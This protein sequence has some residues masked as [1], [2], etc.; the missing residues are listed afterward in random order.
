MKPLHNGG[1]GARCGQAQVWDARCQRI[2][3]YATERRQHEVSAE[4]THKKAAEEGQ[5]GLSMTTLMAV[6]FQA[7]WASSKNGEALA[8]TTCATG[9]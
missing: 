7:P 1:G 3:S 8:L 2:A 9:A 4:C 6:E 5:S